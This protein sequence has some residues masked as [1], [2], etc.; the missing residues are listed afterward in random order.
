VQTN[1]MKRMLLII[2]IVQHNFDPPI[3][4]NL[5]KPRHV[6]LLRRS[7][8]TP[9]VPQLSRLGRER[10]GRPKGSEGP[11]QEVWVVK[12]TGLLLFEARG[13]MLV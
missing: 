3:N 5:P 1:Q 2:D 6:K 7:G 13:S 10:S 11:I 12:P 8:C 4:P 9:T